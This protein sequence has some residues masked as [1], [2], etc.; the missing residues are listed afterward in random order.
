MLGSAR[1]FPPSVARHISIGKT[2]R[3]LSR[4]RNLWHEPLEGTESIGC[5]I[6]PDRELCGGL[7]VHASL[8]DCL[9]FCC[10]NPDSCDRVC[11]NHP[12]FANRVREVDT[13][14][15][16]TIRRARVLA[17]P[18][19]P[20]LVPMVYHRASRYMNP[21][22][23][24][25]ALSLYT[26]FDRRSGRPCFET[27]KSLTEAFGVPPDATVVLTGTDRDRPLERWW[28]LG[29]RRR[30]EVIRAMIGSGVGLIATPNYSLFTDRP[31][32]DNLHAIKRIGIVHEEFLRSGM[33]A[34]LHV[35]GRTDTDFR[36]WAEYISARPEVT[37]IAYEFATGTARQ[38]RLEQHVCWLAD[39]ATGV[40]RPL[41]LVVR[42]GLSQ[43]PT[44]VD[45]YAK[46]TVIDTSVFIKTM[47]RQRAHLSEDNSLCW[48][49]YPTDTGAPVDGL[50]A[51]NLRTMQR[52]VRGLVATAHNGS[53]LSQ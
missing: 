6:C 21:S 31:R 42:G 10:K 52:W 40:G 4:E 16:S 29:E 13:F 47:K 43:L 36:R 7:R 19:L 28:E 49:S 18:E 1:H 22:V 20:H 27:K 5:T 53:G 37:H 46:V 44:L 11:R 9:Q 12:D 34:A 51:I 23:K 14:S 25:V 33:P 50:F 35:N 39:L 48:S 30:L 3:S 2:Q 32:Q 38:G 26:Q 45:I 17:A 41:Q 24:A 15:L 8:F